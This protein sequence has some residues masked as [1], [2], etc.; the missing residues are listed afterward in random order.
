MA[1]GNTDCFQQF[2]TTTASNKYFSSDV[3]SDAKYCNFMLFYMYCIYY[4]Y[5]VLYSTAHKNVQVKC[6]SLN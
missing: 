4:K 3:L 5:T 2:S 1:N 6:A